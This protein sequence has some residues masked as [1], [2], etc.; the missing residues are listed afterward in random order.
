MTIDRL[1]EI[2]ADWQ[3]WMRRPSCKLG[4]PTKSAFLQ[5]GGES[6]SDAFEIMLAASDFRNVIAIDS[7]ITGL[8]K[9]QVTAINARFLECRKPPDYENQLS[10]AID[11]ILTIAQKRG[12]T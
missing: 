7:I 3:R 2:L 12:I 4:Y 8:P 11:N 5:S 1:M 10:M 9:V 6:T